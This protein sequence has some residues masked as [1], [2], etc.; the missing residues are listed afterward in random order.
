[1]PRGRR[2]V[3]RRRAAARALSLSLEV[4]HPRGRGDEKQAGAPGGLEDLLRVLVLR[5][6]A[7]LV[8]LLM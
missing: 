6:A 4:L 2:R 8:V 3:A 5:H 7:P 1:M